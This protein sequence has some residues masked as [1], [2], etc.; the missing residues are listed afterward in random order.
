MYVKAGKDRRA[1]TNE[2]LPDEHV[3]SMKDNGERDGEREEG[4][5]ECLGSDRPDTS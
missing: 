2:R 1:G 5:R 3:W 4:E